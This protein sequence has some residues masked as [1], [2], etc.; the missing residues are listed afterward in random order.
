MRKTIK[1]I[2]KEETTKEY[3]KLELYILNYIFEQ[4]KGMRMFEYFKNSTYNYGKFIDGLKSMFGLTNKML[5]EIL[6]L[7]DKNY[8]GNKF[9]QRD[10]VIRGE[11]K[12]WRVTYSYDVSA[13]QDRFLDVY[14]VEEDDAHNMADAEDYVAAGLAFNDEWGDVETGDTGEIYDSNAEPLQETIKRQLNL[15]K[16]DIKT[17][18][19]DKLLINICKH[20]DKLL[21]D[22]GYTW[23]DISNG[24]LASDEYSSLLTFIENTYGLPVDVAHYAIAVYGENYERINRDWSELLETGIIKPKKTTWHGKKEF[25]ASQWIHQRASA[26]AY[27]EAELNYYDYD[28]YID[29]ED[30]YFDTNDTWDEETEWEKR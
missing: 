10:D 3:T 25:G 18:L 13:W 27:S 22:S 2:L 29:W 8:T 11:A 23:D 26:E 28:G 24:W 19:S 20:I 7:Y 21:T 30:E 16:E 17:R 14:G 12:K 5:A 6:Y 15:L 9:E 1:K 4:L